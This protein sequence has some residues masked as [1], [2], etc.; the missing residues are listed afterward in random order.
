MCKTKHRTVDFG[1]IVYTIKFAYFGS[2][3]MDKI[4]ELVLR[5]FQIFFPNYSLFSVFEI[6]CLKSNTALKHLHVMEFE[7]IKSFR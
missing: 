5:F 7:L 2:Y 6:F 3:A 1:C 4:H